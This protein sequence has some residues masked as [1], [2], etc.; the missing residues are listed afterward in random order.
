[1]DVFGVVQE[2]RTGQNAF[3]FVADVEEDL[4]GGK[5]DDDALKLALAGLLGFVRVAALEVVEKIGKGLLRLVGLFWLGGDGS[6]GRVSLVPKCEGPGAPVDSVRGSTGSGV[7]SGV[8][9]KSSGFSLV[10]MVY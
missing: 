1:V 5:R 4:V 8:G 6:E 3:S 7:I 9:W 2:G 10:M